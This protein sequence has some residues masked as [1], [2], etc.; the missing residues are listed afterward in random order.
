MNLKNNKFQS[1]TSI[2]FI[3]L[4]FSFASYAQSSNKNNSKRNSNLVQSADTLSF[5]F[6][7]DTQEPNLVEKLFL[8]YN[9]NAEARKLIYRKIINISP[10]AV[11]HLGDIVEFGFMNNEWNEVDKFVIKLKKRDIPFYPVPG[12]HEYIFFSHKGIRNFEKRY[13]Y[14]SITGYSKKIKNTAF[15]LFNSNFDDLSP[16]QFS[17]QL[18]WYKTT[19]KNF[20]NDSTIDFII[21]D[22][23]H[24]PFTNSKIVQ[25]SVKVQKYFL[26]DFFKT[27]KCKLFISGHCH[28]FEHFKRK[29]KDF[30][31]I[32]GGGGIQQPL[33][34]GTNEKYKDLFSD[35]L[36]TR[37]FHFINI[38][39]FKNT[40][41]V[42]L[43]MIDKNFKR[44]KRSTQIILKDKSRLVPQ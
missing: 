26:P 36:R 10:D 42:D 18:N 2:L 3:V 16:K 34:I 21:V 15:V 35:S 14:A 32:G 9:N 11:F 22:C 23:H 33:F 24:S 29:G 20:E 41:L 12:N 31:V 30:L 28:A 38:K 1:L 25:P 8:K 43:Y 40:M 7:S 4:F 39:V 5:C 13:P 37:M 17:K 27:K 19:L 44:F 6:V